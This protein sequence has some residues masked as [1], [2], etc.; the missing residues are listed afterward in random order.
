M[1]EKLFEPITIKNVEIKNRLFVPPMVVNFCGPNGEI[2]EE[3][4]RYHEEKAKGGR[5]GTQK[6]AA[7]K[8]AG[9]SQFEGK[10]GDD[11][12]AFE[13]ALRPQP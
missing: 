8:D 6:A 1:F 11:P 4:T 2:T 5:A 13:K 7:G 12:G 10:S 3:F 9:I